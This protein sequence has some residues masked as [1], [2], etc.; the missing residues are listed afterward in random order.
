LSWIVI[1]ANSSRWCLRG[2]L[3]RSDPVTIDLMVT[4]DVG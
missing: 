4:I 2:G 1:M 3:H